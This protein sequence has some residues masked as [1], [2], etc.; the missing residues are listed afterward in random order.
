MFA[1]EKLQ[2]YR[3]ALD[4]AAKAA[5]WTTAW[6]KRHALVDHLSRAAESV[7][8]NLAEAARQRGV[9]ARL[10]IADYAIGSSLEC[11]GCLDVARIKGLLTRFEANEQ[12]HHLCQVTGMLIGLRKAWAQSVALEDALPYRG[13]L[14]RSQGASSFHHER[15]VVYQAALGFVEWFVS[16][17]GTEAL[18][19]RLFRQIDEAGTCVVLNIAEGNGRYAELDHQRF[20]QIAQSGSVRAAVYVDLCVKGGLW[21]EAEGASGKAHLRQISTLL[22]GF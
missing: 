21:G 16:Q 4:F 20:L 14:Q 15:L 9:P 1:H 7:V 2:V 10:K 8:S 22:S 17:T 13:E 3:E 19:K 11:A 18:T 6:D 5:V 12:K